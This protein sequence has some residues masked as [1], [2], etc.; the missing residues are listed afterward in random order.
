MVHA[1]GPAVQKDDGRG[2]ITNRGP[3]VMWA[4]LSDALGT[5][6]HLR[7]AHVQ[8]EGHRHAQYEMASCV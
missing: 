5:H 1:P 2:A 7:E 8:G 6:D 3:G 4:V